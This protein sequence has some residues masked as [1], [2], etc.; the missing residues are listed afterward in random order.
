[1]RQL[2]RNQWTEDNYHHLRQM[3]DN[4]RQGDDNR[5][6]KPSYIVMDWDNTS[7]VFDAEEA[8]FLYQVKHLVYR[9]ES[10]E[11]NRIISLGLPLDQQINDQVTLTWQE[12][13]QEVSGTYRQL[14][15]AYAG[16]A[17]ELSL[18]E[19]RK[20]PEYDLFVRQMAVF[21][22]LLVKN[23]S[24]QTHCLWVIYLF[25]GMTETEVR[26]LATDSLTYWLAESPHKELFKVSMAG[27]HFET[28][29]KLG[30]KVIPEVQ[31]LYQTLL[32]NGIDVYIC[33]ASFQDVIDVFATNP[34][35]GYCLPDNRVMALQ[36]KRDEEGRYLPEIPDDYIPT[37][38]AGKAENIRRRLVAEYGMQPIL[39]GGDS[40]GDYEMLTEFNETSYRLII[41]LEQT[42]KIGDLIAKGVASDNQSPIYLIQGRDEVAGRYH[43]RTTSRYLE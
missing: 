42:G 39:V 26:Q 37:L 2:E 34:V 7:I 43:Q 22:H 3:I 27:I 35:F 13:V 38:K 14:Y 33:S 12:L 6:E 5:N 23:L 16:M 10:E 30:L 28:G 21:Y 41:H 32:A 29:Y 20:K 8:V 31:D 18:A 4:Y 24:Y 36:L 9:L 17:G 1:M 40:Q 19:I 25:A 15:Q 11:F